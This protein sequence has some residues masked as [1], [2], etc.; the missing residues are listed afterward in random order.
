MRRSW[1]TTWVASA[2]ILAFQVPNLFR[3]LLGEGALTA[4]FIPIFKQKEVKEGE[5]EMW[6]SANAVISGLV[7]AAG[8]VTV[9]AVL[10]ISLALAVGRFEAE[11]ALMLRLLRADVPLHAAGVPGGGVHRHGQRPRPLLR[12][13]AGRG[14][15]QH[16]HD[17]QRAAAG[18]AHGPDAGAADL[19]P[20]HRRGAW[21]G[22][23]RRSSN[24]RAS[25]ARATATSGF[26]PG[27]TRP[28][29]RSCAR[30][31]PARSAWPPSRS[32]CWSRSAFRSGSTRPSSPPSTTRCG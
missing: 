20:G 6:R 19:R 3:R 4:A 12:A 1:A 28:C 5:A 17:R 26:R 24:C 31:C 25:P 30:C 13:G 8:A 7:I 11:T 23:P 27:A 29:G 9:L 15:A 16:D 18:P 32:T 10:G 22:W 14:R 2:F 21:P